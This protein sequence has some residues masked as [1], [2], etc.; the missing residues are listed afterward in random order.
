MAQSRIHRYLRHGTMHQLSV[1]ESVARHGNFTRAAEELYMAQPTVSVQIKKLTETIGMPLF[2]QVGNHI[3]LTET[4]R[5]LLGACREIF[6]ALVKVE[7]KLSSIRGL[8]SGRLQLAV[9]STGK[10]FAPR[11]LAAFV[12]QH[13]G[14]DISLQVHNRQS[15]VERL[16]N[17]V[18]DLYIF[19]NPPPDVEVVMQQILPNPMVVFARA[20]HVLAG[21]R[22]IPFERMAKEPFLMRE[23]GSGTRTVTE[24]AFAQHG[25]QP[26]FRM[27]FASN[28]AIRE[29]ILAGI[30]VSILSRYTFGLEPGHDQ[31]VILDVEGFPLECHWYFV[32]PVG[33]QLPMVAHAFMDFTREHVREFVPHLSAPGPGTHA[34]Q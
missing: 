14:I 26:Q 3:H 21:Q 17:N 32:Y 31:L 7:D 8:Q 16:V 15:L 29:G 27:E 25:L 6:Q 20:D 18:D 1:F 23:P 4:G 33:K 30:G 11:M 28:E 13:P 24:E 34:N 22:H 2:E 10:Y 12:Q 9:S 5:E 19:A